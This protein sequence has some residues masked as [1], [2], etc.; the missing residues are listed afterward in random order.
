MQVQ[1]A[2]SSHSSH[3]PQNVLLAQFS[4]YVHKG[5][6]GPHSFHFRSTL[7]YHLIV[8]DNYL[9]VLS[10]LSFPGSPHVVTL[11]RPQSLHVLYEQCLGEVP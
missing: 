3:H 8:D 4:L 5:G 7:I 10:R 9:T 6:L 1:L 11:Q 2:T